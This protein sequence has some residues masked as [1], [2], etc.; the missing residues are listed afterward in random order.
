MAVFEQRDWLTS[1]SR[2]HMKSD[3]LVMSWCGASSFERGTARLPWAVVGKTALRPVDPMAQLDGRDAG[4]G[5]WG[6][7][8]NQIW[9]QD[10]WTRGVGHYARVHEEPRRTDLH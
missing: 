1:F 5:S 4:H 6:W 7:I 2:T 8:E 3:R 10:E 9:L